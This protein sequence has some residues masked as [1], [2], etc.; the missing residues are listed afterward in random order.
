MKLSTKHLRCL[1][2]QNV[3]QNKCIEFQSGPY[4]GLFESKCSR[5]SSKWL[6]CPSHDLRWGR[7]RYCYAQEHI[8]MFHANSNLNATDGYNNKKQKLED[9]SVNNSEFY[10]EE[11]DFDVVDESD[12]SSHS[13]VSVTDVELTKFI[14]SHD[15]AELS[16]YSPKVKRYLQCERKCIGD[17][18]KRIVACAFAMNNNTDHEEI[19]WDEINY[20]I[21]TAMFCCSLSSCQQAQLGEICEMLLNN[22]N[23][24][25]NEYS[26]FTMSRI[27]VSSIDVDRFYL[28]R[29][30]SIAQN[31]P[32]PKIIELDDHACVSIKE[33]IYHVLYFSIP[34]DGF[35]INDTSSDYKNI[36][37]SSSLVSKTKISNL[38]RTQV[39]S[40]LQTNGL[41][42][43]IIPIVLWSDDFEPNH[44]KQHKKSTWIKT[45][46]VAPP[47]ECQTSTKHTYVIC[48][49][50]KDKDHEIVNKYFADE[51]KELSS[52]TYM[53]CKATN[54]NIPVVV[55]V[56]AISADRPER[57]ALNC[58]LGHGGTTS[59]RWRYSAYVNQSKLKS[60]RQCL[61][62]RIKS[63][64]E[65]ASKFCSNCY[66]WDY[67]HP[68][69]CVRKP[70]D[71][72]C[73][74]HPD[75]PSP[76]RG[77]EVENVSLLY[78]IELTYDVMIQGVRLCFFNC[79]QGYWTKASA[80]TYLK[81]I[82][83]NESYG[84]NNVYLPAI[85]CRRNITKVSDNVFDNLIFPVHWNCGISLDQCIDTPMHQ[86]FQ[87][88][89]KSVMEKT[90]SWLTQKDNSHYKAFGDYVNSSLSMIHDI[91]L[92]WCRMEPFMRGR[93][94]TLGGWQAEQYVAFTR[95][96]I[97]VYSA[98]R[99]VVGD[100]EVGIDE[101]EC[102]VQAL[103]S[104]IC[105]LMS[106]DD[107]DSSLLLK[108]IKVFLSSCDMFEQ[109]A[110]I[111][112]D[113]DAFWYT[114]G[115]F[116]SLL[117][118]P[119]QIAKFGSI[120]MYWEGS[121]ERSIQQIKPFLMNIRQ[122]ASYFKTK[123]NYM[124][125]SETLHTINQINMQHI[126]KLGSTSSQRGYEKHSPFKTYSAHD[127]IM[128]LLDSN[129][130]ISVV[131]LSYAQQSP[132]F[133]ICQRTKSP[134]ICSLWEVKFFDNEGFNKC[135]MWYSPIEIFLVNNDENLTQHDI[136][137][138]SDDFAVLCPCISSNKQ[139]HKYYTV[140]CQSWKYRNKY[141]ELS[142][143]SLSEFLFESSIDNY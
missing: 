125:V 80:M 37:P 121:R 94:Y 39:K 73:S 33:V 45:I 128:T 34:I 123:I 32:I 21:K 113:D 85:R 99:D 102:M 41:S 84:H 67:N 82:G 79:F 14:A 1:K 71:Y 26:P 55:K 3:Y 136:H 143:P 74:Q 75:S 132:R 43:L 36:I 18:I 19:T 98:I 101:H 111:M 120:R 27:P 140:I 76:P 87:G 104:L 51:L 56:L 92:N 106:D 81:S 105:L 142:F 12:E 70:S 110:Y 122:T 138:L 16:C 114:K 9:N 17:G 28:K 20:H 64:R 129:N 127:N 10:N 116:L 107:I 35:L 2:C 65:E 61:R 25:S 90:M 4:C 66:D 119:Q 38:I 23:N 42:P 46:T 91:G 103:L 130:V 24:G 86:L 50:P 53:Y 54:N 78:P 77:R 57:C 124:Y 96:I 47:H 97:L 141:N 69:M 40:R 88:I 137:L 63:S 72:P 48:L 59:R 15:D 118:L 139:L 44:V 62:E 11:N 135:G 133:Y 31:L 30:T 60:C 93:S 8:R 5:C 126:S 7:L 58:M 117:N 95:C 115:N 6:V 109:K 49:G 13:N 131:Y 29:S 100:D 52:P 112:N 89:V 108:H 68:N 134:K 22:I 83:V